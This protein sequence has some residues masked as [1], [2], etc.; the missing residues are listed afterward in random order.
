MKILIVFI[1]AI[2]I[3]LFVYAYSKEDPYLSDAEKGVNT[4]LAQAAKQ[5]EKKYH[6]KVIG[7]GAG[8]PRR[9]INLLIL[10]F[11]ING[12]L[13]QDEARKL[14]VECVEEF[15]QIA[16]SDEKIRPYMKNFPFTPENLDLSVFI[17]DKN[18]QDIYN[19]ALGLAASR[20]GKL[21]YKTYNKG[22]FGYASEIEESYE[23]AL[24]I[25]NGQRGLD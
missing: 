4:L 5:L 3:S 20:H 18:G 2:I 17:Y 9:V 10:S 22:S 15:L 14:L 23:E 25:V 8:M 6:M 7:E 16:N 19:P 24:K 21:F 1:I 11:R 12:S 13:T